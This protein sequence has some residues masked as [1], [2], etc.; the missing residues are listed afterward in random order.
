[1]KALHIA[2]LV[3]VSVIFF[4]TYS[5]SMEQGGD[6]STKVVSVPIG[7]VATLDRAVG[8]P[9]SEGGD[10][11]YSHA[12]HLTFELIARF[13]HYN[14]ETKHPDDHYDDHVY[15]PK[16]VHYSAR[17]NKVYV[18]SL[19]GMATAIY[20]PV[21]LIKESAILHRFNS[22]NSSLFSNDN[23][24]E[25]S[26]FPDDGTVPFPNIF[27]GKPVEFA[28]TH[29][30]RYLWVSYYRRSFDRNGSLPSA[31]AVIDTDSDRIVK[32]M[33]T[34]PVPKML[35]ASPDGKWLAVVHWGDNTVGLIDVSGDDPSEFQRAGLI[36]VG[37]KFQLERDED[38][39]RDRECGLCL[40]GAAFTSDGKYLFVGR[41]RGGGIAVI[42]VMTQSY[43]G[44]VFGMKPTP[45][46]LTL[47]KDGSILYLSSNVSGYVSS[48]RAKDLIDA[49]LSGGKSLKPLQS[50]YSGPGAR[51][52][53]L[54]PD[55]SLLFATVNRES[56]VAVIDSSNMEILLYIPTDSFPVGLDIAPDGSQLWVTSQGRNGRG[57]NSV[58]VYRV[59]RKQDMQQVAGADEIPGGRIPRRL[60]R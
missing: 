6:K 2:M 33:P 52:I 29:N 9:P 4:G 16:S 23:S 59:L 24:A 13:Q 41:M 56:K 14:P 26:S 11:G 25:W 50:V 44:T 38:V 37:K 27:F 34:G 22:K 58:T 49:A 12:P 3:M 47:S 39:N 46:H 20:D 8:A 36:K 1:M 7:T 17:A 28:E 53:V 21:K 48:Y 42:D 45:R 54:S 15:S 51:T 19:E 10:A 18:N 55:G 32:V 57:G 30:G 5:H 31:V 43:I 40:R 60:P 35:A